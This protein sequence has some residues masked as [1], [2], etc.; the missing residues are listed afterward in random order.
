MSAG[1]GAGNASLSR[2]ATSGTGLAP[3]QASQALLQNLGGSGTSNAA[4]ARLAQPVIAREDT[5]GAP[6]VTEGETE[7]DPDAAVKSR[8]SGP[9]PQLQMPGGT[10]LPVGLP[11]EAGTSSRWDGSW[12]TPT[13]HLGVSVPVPP[14]RAEVGGY[15]GASAK[16]AGNASVNWTRTKGA[17]RP[18]ADTISVGADF[19][20]NA[21]LAGGLYAGFVVGV[22]ELLDIGPIVKGGMKL[23]GSGSAKASGELKREGD[24]EKMEFGDW[25]GNV[26]VDIN[27]KGKAKLTGG[28]Y[29]HWTLLWMSGDEK[30]YELKDWEVATV[31]VKGSGTLDTKGGAD[32]KMDK[33]DFILGTPQPQLKS[34]KKGNSS[35]NTRR[36]P[37]GEGGPIYMK[38]ME[39]GD[40]DRARQARA[41]FARV[42]AREAA[43]PPGSAAAEPDENAPAA[44][45][46]DP[47]APGAAGAAP[48]PAGG[49]V[50]ADPTDEAQRNREIAAKGKPTGGA[51]EPALIVAEPSENQ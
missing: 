26:K 11:H 19:N 39:G 3:G 35:I 14:G 38:R 33:L 9:Q 6:P 25:S 32:F 49:P 5:P 45:A 37:R 1:G 40:D 36:G 4:L 42:V 44:A 27:L 41:A 10:I 17:S 21:N 16:A 43:A 29:I 50:P 48:G 2:L 13:K 46:A 22:P 51:G 24:P 7:T 28:A 20:V 30:I 47:A 15:L 31:D 12:E 18:V 34:E 8:A 23:E